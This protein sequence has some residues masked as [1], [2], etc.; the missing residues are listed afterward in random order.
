M[1]NTAMTNDDDT[2]K[3]TKHQEQQ[4]KELERF[5]QHLKGANLLYG[6]ALDG[7][8]PGL[9]AASDAIAA[10]D[11]DAKMAAADED[12]YHM[13][14]EAVTKDLDDIDVLE[15]ELEADDREEQ[16]LLADDEAEH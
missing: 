11:M 7:M 8:E 2:Q 12:V 16:A 4:M 10:A 3:P 6:S 13:V 5:E 9:K 1:T 15:A 14:N